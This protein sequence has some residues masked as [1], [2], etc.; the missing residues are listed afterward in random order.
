MGKPVAFDT[1]EACIG[2]ETHVQLNT[3]SKIF[4][5]CP[6]RIVKT[7]NTNICP[8]CTGYPGVLPT[9]NKEAIHAAIAMG[10]ATRSTIALDS[11]F[12]RKHYFY[13][14]LPKNFQ[15]TQAD[16]PIC[17]E[18][19]VTIFDETGITKDIRLV[20]IH[21][22]EDA[23]KNMHGPT[24]SFVDLNRTGTP[25]LEIVSYPDISS[26]QEA[27]AYLK[28]LRN[29][30]LH[31]N[32]GS[33]NMDEGALRADTNISVRKKGEKK[34]GT[35]VELKNINSFKFVG[36]AI[37]YEISRQIEALESGQKIY[38]ETRSWDQHAKQTIV[39]RSKEEAADYRYFHEPDLPTLHISQ[40]L[41]DQLNNNLPELPAQRLA[42]Y[43][44]QGLS[45]YEATILIDDLALARYFDAAYLDT[46]YLDTASAKKASKT[47]VNW[48]LRDVIGYLNEQKITLEHFKITPEYLAELV[49]LIDN[50]TINTSVAQEVFEQAAQTGKSPKVLV[51]EQGLTQI[52]DT[53]ELERI[54]AQVLAQHPQQVTAYQSGNQKLFGFLVGQAMKEAKGRANPHVINEILKKLLQ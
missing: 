38:Q 45:T 46:A 16:R 12:A 19:T 22:E 15:I 43:Q 53:Q 26:A 3:Q 50:K 51:Q 39:M 44:Q 17:A 25:L 8:I 21:L 30:V 34:L 49:E 7:P 2:I 47:L 11:V 36:D 27:R 40:E 9:V 31:L 32:I 48:V 18:G 28:T 14:D 33:G 29:I 41:V 23:G 24:E 52:D 20:R 42:R 35:K 4:C 37:E 1:Y 10:L 5:S 13:P 6:N 54:V